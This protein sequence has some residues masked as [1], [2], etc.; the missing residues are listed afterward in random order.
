MSYI[1]KLCFFIWILC[2]FM[3]Y[4]FANAKDVVD[5]PSLVEACDYDNVLTG[6]VEVEIQGDKAL[7]KQSDDSGHGT[8]ATVSATDPVIQ[9]IKIAQERAA[10][11]EKSDTYEI[12]LLM[13]LNTPVC[14]TDFLHGQLWISE[15]VEKDDYYAVKLCYEGSGTC[16]YEKITKR[17]ALG[18]ELTAYGATQIEDHLGVMKHTKEGLILT[19][20]AKPHPGSQE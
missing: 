20:W 4:S 15:L 14:A 19:L 17:S 6:H 9:M 5:F 8:H 11:H 18:G 12:A 3:P 2:A 13:R 7:I 16:W 10:A 1:K